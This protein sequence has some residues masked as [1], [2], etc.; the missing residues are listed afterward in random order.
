M[1]TTNH[2]GAS[3][4][5]RTRQEGEVL[6]EYNKGTLGASELQSFTRWETS[7]PIAMTIIDHLKNI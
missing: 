5:Y 4:I 3:M 7:E 2:P 6:D 1:L